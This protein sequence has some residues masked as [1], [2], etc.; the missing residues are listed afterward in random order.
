M[1]RGQRGLA[2]DTIIARYGE[3]LFF[4]EKFGTSAAKGL[5]NAASSMATLLSRETGIDVRISPVLAVHSGK[6][7]GGD[8]IWGWGGTI[9]GEGLTV[10]YPRRIARWIR[11]QDDAELTDDQ[12]ELLARTAARILRR[13]S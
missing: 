5:I 10:A 7:V 4:D 13:M 9:T 12:I 2:P 8:G 1:D 6:I 11:S 3:R